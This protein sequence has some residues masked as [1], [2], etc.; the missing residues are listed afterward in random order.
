V[1]PEPTYVVFRAGKLDD[2][3]AAMESLAAAHAGWINFQ[4]AVDVA[5]LP[6]AGGGFFGIFGGK[7]PDVPLGT[8]LPASAPKRGRAEPPRIGLQHG[9]GTR[10][11][12]RL[13]ELGHPVPDGWVVQ[14]D[15][16]RKGLVV[17]VPPDVPHADVLTWLLGA[18]RALS[19]VPLVDDWRAEVY[20]V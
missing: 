20:R 17:A 9:A 8:W 14:Q 13:A 15:Y 11:K 1:T 16:V 7:G 19:N 12:R 10:A 6:S 5:D 2:A 3:V 18:A 4:P